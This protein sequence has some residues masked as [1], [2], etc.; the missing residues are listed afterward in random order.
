MNIKEFVG[1]YRNH[2]VLFIGTG[3]SLRY[4]QNSY[5][6]DGLLKHISRELAGND[7]YYFD[8]K[9]RC[10]VNGVFKYDR[11]ASALEESFNEACKADRHGKF[12]SV[13]DAFYAGMESN[14]N[15]SRLKI[16]ICQLLSDLNINEDKSDELVALKKAAKNIGSIIT[17]NYDS[18]IETI[19]EFSPL[20]GNDILLSNPYGSV[21]KIHGCVSQPN[22]IVITAQ[23]YTAFFERYELIRAQLLSLFIHN[24]IIFVGYSISDENIKALLRTVFSYVSPNSDVAQRVKDNFLL[25]EREKDSKSEEVVEHDIDIEGMSTIRINKIKTDNFSYLYESLA[26]LALPVS[27]MD[28]RKVQNVVHEILAGGD[29]KV[30]ITEDLDTLKNGEKIL[31]IGSAKTITYQYLTVSEMIS[32]YFRI[33]EEENDRLLE[34]INKQKIQASQFFPV[35]GF[36]KICKNITEEVALKKQQVEKITKLL[37]GV[38]AKHQREFSTVEEFIKDQ[39]LAD[40]YRPNAIAWAAVNGYLSVAEFEVYLKSIADKTSTSYRRMLCVYDSLKYGTPAV[41]AKT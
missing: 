27:A 3:F 8:I 14:V 16:Y 19:F 1:R 21:Y 11:I 35:F 13:N 36:S 38:E 5:T 37:D 9:S 22:R 12:K 26:A 17:T 18:L 4:L 15:L 6:W 30:T 39:T 32:S 41:T 10:E 40:T 33:I 23:D 7:E 34:L 20:I 28:V 31:A 2:P 25:V 29:I 24:P